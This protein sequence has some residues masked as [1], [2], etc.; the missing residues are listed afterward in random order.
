MIALYISLYAVVGIFL[1][2]LMTLSGKAN[3][4]K[5]PTI[6]LK[7]AVG[8][9]FVLFWFVLAP[10]MYFNQMNPKK[11]NVTKNTQN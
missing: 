10:V 5:V 6:E 8:L 7:F 11:K 2:L 3:W 1:L 4:I 9:I